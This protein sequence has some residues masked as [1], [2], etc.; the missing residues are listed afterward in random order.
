MS[1]CREGETGTQE[2]PGERG[3]EGEDQERDGARHD[4]RLSV[5]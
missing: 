1:R 2:A 5:Q 3:G 4:G